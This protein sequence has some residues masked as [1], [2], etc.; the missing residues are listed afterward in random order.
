M[1]YADKDFTPSTGSMMPSHTE[2]H[3]ATLVFKETRWHKKLS[4]ENWSS[5][6]AAQ[7]VTLKPGNTPSIMLNVL[8]VQFCVENLNAINFSSQTTQEN[9]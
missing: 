4:D 9:I 3:R 1:A 5:M 2:T 7:Q 6:T 8:N